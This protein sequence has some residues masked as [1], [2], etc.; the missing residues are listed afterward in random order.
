MLRLLISGMGIASFASRTRPTCAAHHCLTI[1]QPKQLQTGTI[2]RIAD[3]AT[4]MIAS[5]SFLLIGMQCIARTNVLGEMHEI[6]R[7]VAVGLCRLI[8]LGV[9]CRRLDCR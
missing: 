4:T 6:A 5:S 3:S 7:V 1:S 2:H 9:G 8:L